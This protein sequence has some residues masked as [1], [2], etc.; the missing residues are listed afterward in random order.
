MRFTQGTLPTP[1]CYAICILKFWKYQ[2][3]VR[4]SGAAGQA[5][6]GFDKAKAGIG[7]A[8]AGIGKAAGKAKA[9]ISKIKSRLLGKFRKKKNQ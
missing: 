4:K 6:V 9:G 7:K 3:K 8:K 2:Q 1:L 5:K